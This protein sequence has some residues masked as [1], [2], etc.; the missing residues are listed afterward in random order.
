MVHSEAHL[1]VSRGTIAAFSA[2]CA[3][4]GRS[5]R[6][7][8]RPGQAPAVAICSTRPRQP[9]PSRP[10]DGPKGGTLPL[11]WY[12]GGVLSEATKTPPPAV[13]APVAGCAKDFLPAGPPSGSRRGQHT[14]LGTGPPQN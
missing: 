9:S 11:P 10:F 5:R 4:I 8:R 7:R 2:D 13:P 14:N 1:Y 3:Q 6:A 12:R